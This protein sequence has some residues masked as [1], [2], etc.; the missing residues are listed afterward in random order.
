MSLASLQPRRALGRVLSES[1]FPALL[2]S[3]DPPGSPRLLPSCWVRET[4][5]NCLVSLELRQDLQP[6]ICQLSHQVMSLRWGLTNSD[7]YRAQADS[8]SEQSKPASHAK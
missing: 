1:E 6:T 5:G 4:E 2:L 3:A 7:T 8:V